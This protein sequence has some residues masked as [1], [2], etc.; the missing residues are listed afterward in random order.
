LA[1]VFSIVAVA[2][3]LTLLHVGR[4]H[5]GQWCD[6]G[7]FLRDHRKQLGGDWVHWLVRGLE[8]A[9]AALAVFVASVQA[10]RMVRS[11]K[12]C[13]TCE[14]FME[15]SELPEVG[16]GGLHI[17]TAAA[18]AGEVE[19]VSYLFDDPPPG[20]EGK[21]VLFHCPICGEGFLETHAQFHASWT[22]ED[23]KTETKVTSWMTA[24]V[25]L[26]EKEV[27]LLRAFIVE[28]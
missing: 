9:G 27:E 24:S 26:G 21:A 20:K 8:I 4:Q 3:S 28:R 7:N 17:L 18:S 10:S 22:K 11:K 23:G 13:E 25:P 15:E 12:F 5:F 14:L 2:V 6:P 16:L 19:A 1:A